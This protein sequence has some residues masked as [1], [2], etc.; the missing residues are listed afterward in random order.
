MYNFKTKLSIH[1]SRTRLFGLTMPIY[2]FNVAFWLSSVIMI[3]KEIFNWKLKFSTLICTLITQ[4][5][6]PVRKLF[7]VLL[8]PGSDIVPDVV[9][10]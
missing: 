10:H 4:F 3:V 7:M 2:K 6:Y 8:K 5:L 9:I 1:C